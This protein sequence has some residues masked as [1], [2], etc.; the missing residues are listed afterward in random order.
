MIKKTKI[1]LLTNKESKKKIFKSLKKIFNN[2]KIIV[3][4][5]SKPG[6]NSN[7]KFKKLF[8]LYI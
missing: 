3:K 6:L 2:E 8:R 5:F 4:V 1:L 7:F